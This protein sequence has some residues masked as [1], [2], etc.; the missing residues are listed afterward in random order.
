MQLR[1]GI[2]LTRILRHLPLLRL[3]PKT[4]TV[5]LIQ[6]RL[7]GMRWIVGA[8]VHAFWMGRYEVEQQRRFEQTVTAGHV[9]FDVG[10]HAGFYT[11][12]AS[13]LVG[14]SGRVIAFEP[15][16][17]NLR[18]LRKHLVLNHLTNVQVMEAA[19]SDVSG[20][21]FFEVGSST[22]TGRLAPEGPF[23]VRTVSLDDLARQGAVPVPDVVKIDIEGGETRA[24]A[25]ARALLAEH[26]PTLFL[27]THGSEP[28]RACCTLLEAAGYCVEDMTARTGGS[29]EEPDGL[30]ACRA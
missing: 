14:D 1:S 24:L 8:G 27:S 25:G 18:Y 15:L 10:A 22:T 2:W 7:R 16:P 6:G 4:V 11:L 20:E 19:V 23:Q 13:A 3:L 5:T 9:V 26:H 30:F 12:L 28:H 17:C 29:P 21:S